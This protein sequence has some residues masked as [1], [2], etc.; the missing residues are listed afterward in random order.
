MPAFLQLKD[1]DKQFGPR[2]IFD[3]ASVTL[4]SEKKT[5]FI[6]RNGAG[7][8]TLC[9][10]ILGQDTADSGEVIQSADLRL[11]YLDQHDPFTPEETALDFLMRHTGQEAWRCGEVAGRFQLKHDLLDTRIKNLSG[12][13]QTRIKLTSMLL[14][15]PN[16]LI[17]DEPSNY[18]DLKTLILLEEF[19][20]DFDGGFLIVS[21]DR[22]FL[23]KTCDHTLEAERGRLTLYPGTVEEYLTFK[24]EGQAQ[25][26]SYNQTIES[27]RKQ[28]QAFV[29]RFHA[30]ASKA[31]QARSKMKQIE[32]LK[33]IDLAEAQHNVQIKIPAIQRRQGPAFTCEHLSIGYPEKLVAKD[34]RIEV[35]HGAHVA[36]LGDNGQGKTTFLRTLAADLAP[37]GGMFKWG[38][39]CEIAYYAQHVV[40]TL[41]PKHDVFTHLERHAADAVTRQELLAMAGSFLFKGHDVKKP[42]SVLS[43]GEGARL[44]L[45]GLLL[46]KRSVLL[47]DEPT[48]H[49]DFETVEALGAALRQFPG[50]V[51]FISHDR[52]FVNMVATQIVEVKHGAVIHYPGSYADYVYRLENQVRQELEAEDGARA[53][54]APKVKTPSDYHLRKQRESAKRKLAGKIK[55]SE[56]QQAASRREKESLE[57]EMAANPAL[58]NRE[59]T[60]R[61]A[62]LAALIQEE[63]RR[64]IQLTEQLEALAK[65]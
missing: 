18:L 15:E 37:T 62:T 57:S 58:W 33:T 60:D 56:A 19:L 47:L 65:G 10:I 61:C 22:E 42:V 50:T 9:K 40:A 3:D 14:R 29:D 28:L 4:D 7:K 20:Q 46:M 25:A 52:T 34:I 27:K 2:V 5:G 1:I 11:S 38:F 53:E 8:S 48:N 26:I 12:G 55:R 39:G 24:A 36:V 59:L 30:K 35:D 32:K 21:H 51:F 54:L 6:G 13:Y 17:L 43:G 44:C 23:K 64:W 41:N 31:A 16:F 63:E 49:L 45:A